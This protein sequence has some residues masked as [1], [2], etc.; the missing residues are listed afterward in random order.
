MTLVRKQAFKIIFHQKILK[1]LKPPYK[2]LYHPSINK[3]LRPFI[4]AVQPIFSEIE[5]IMPVVGRISIALPDGKKFCMVSDG[6]DAIANTIYY[7]GIKYFEGETIPYFAKLASCSKN[8]FDIGAN[9]GIYAIIAAIENPDAKVYAFEPHPGI[10][11][12]LKE[13][14]SVNSLEN[15][16]AELSALTNKDGT[17]DL[18]IPAGR[19]DGIEQKL[20]TTS[21]TRKDFRKA[22]DIV[23][24]SAMKLDSYCRAKG[25]NQVDLLKI[26]TEAT[27]HLVIEGGMETIK[28]DQPII[29][30]EV[31]CGMTE[32]FL[33]EQLDPIGY[34]YYW[35]SDSGPVKQETIMGHNTD[36]NYLFVTDKRKAILRDLGIL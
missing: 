11:D 20:P 3:L 35:L 7:N 29:F 17:I 4:R 36:M 1:I 26:D 27:E 12:Y 6:Y 23:K 33:H 14:I 13:N 34:E 10:F 31:L 24:V 15:I 2:Y 5:I 8:I 25:I 28:R 19:Y 9:T 18:Y 30:S 16:E 21:S 32:R 22:Q